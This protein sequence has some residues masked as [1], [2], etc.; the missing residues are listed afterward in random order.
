MR[1]SGEIEGGS[2]VSRVY[3]DTEDFIQIREQRA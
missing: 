1:I 2:L 3:S